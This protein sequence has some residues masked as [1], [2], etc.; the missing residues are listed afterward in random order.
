MPGRLP[1]L[2]VHHPSRGRHD[3]ID[4][5]PGTTVTQKQE[6]AAAKRRYERQQASAGRQAAQENRMARMATVVVTVVLLLGL[7]GFF[8]GRLSDSTPGATTPDTTASSSALTAAGCP[9]P[10]TPPGP[11]TA[12][13]DLPPVA[14]VAGKAWTATIATNCGDIVVDL[15][16]KAAPQAVASFTQLATLNYWLNSPCHRLT[17]FP[18]LKVLQCGDPTGTGS[19]TPGYGFAVENAPKDAKY[20]RGTLAMARTQDPKKGNGGQFFIVYGDSEL[21]DPAGYTIF[22]QVTSGLDI[23]DKEAAA[24]ISGDNPQ[25][26][27]PSAPISILRVAVTEK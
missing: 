27:A 17:A 1:R 7:V 16:A 23:V 26:G 5:E 13:L 11:T 8:G 21:A 10:P 14:T 22:G 6:R 24:G 4:E 15:D 9:Q 20:P 12:K 18:G 2:R 3:F 19:G 25:D